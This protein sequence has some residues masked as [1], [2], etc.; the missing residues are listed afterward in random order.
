MPGCPGGI[1]TNGAP[2]DTARHDYDFVDELAR[3]RPR[4]R[5]AGQQARF[6]KW[7]SYFE[8]LRAIAKVGCDC[9]EMDGVMRRLAS[10]TEPSAQKAFARDTA[11]PARI[12][13]NEDWGRMMTLAIETA[14]TWGGIGVV[15]GQ[16]MMNRG[17]CNLLERHDPALRAALGEDL[18]ASALPWREYRGKPRLF[19]VTARSLADRGESLGLRIIALDNQPV[20]AVI[21]HHRL[22][23]RGKW[24][25]TPATHL[26]R[27]V[28]EAKL[29]PAQDDY[30]YYLTASTAGGAKLVWPASA[31]HQGASL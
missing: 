29:P 25:A 16:E 22:L 26:A 2:W 27:A 13:L 1:G 6:D 20:S 18:P 17:E 21:V 10:I 5:G 14:E 9:G 15:M 19:A 8:Y 31:P 4:I 30:E 23:G 11:L 7:V 24:Q 12:R 3:L 28:Y